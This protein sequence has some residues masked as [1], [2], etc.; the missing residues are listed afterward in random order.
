[1]K[2]ATLVFILIFGGQ[3]VLEQDSNAKLHNP[4]PGM[5]EME[6]VRLTYG[7]DFPVKLGTVKV[8]GTIDDF[9]AMKWGV[10]YF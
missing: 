1:M 6:L 8:D 10:K 2:I 5:P 9:S 4:H 3:L 7:A